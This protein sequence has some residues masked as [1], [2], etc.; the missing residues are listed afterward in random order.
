MCLHSRDERIIREFALKKPV[1]RVL[2]NTPGALGGVGATTGLPPALTL[3][4][5]SVG[6]SATSDNV[7]PMNL[8]N[9]RRLA[10]GLLELEDLRSGRTIPSKESEVVRSA[11][12]G[13]PQKP[14]KAKGSY[15][16]NGP[17][18]LGNAAH[19]VEVT[20]SQPYNRLPSKQPMP[21]SK[22]RTSAF[23]AKSTSAA[24]SSP[25]WSAAMSAL[26]RQLPKPAAQQ[27]TALATSSPS[28]SF[29][30]RTAKWN[31]SFRPSTSTRNPLCLRRTVA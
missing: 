20:T 14:P 26:S 17:A 23:A 16:A 8:I 21:W 3:G 4:C 25:S 22:R 12:G 24:V 6:G 31:T 5:G 10:Y 18:Y 28:M 1:S 9:V 2:V 7:G 29:R 15:L 27:L 11:S 30:V 19:S 13:S